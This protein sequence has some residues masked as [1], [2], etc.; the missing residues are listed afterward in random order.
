M[1]CK[2]DK[3]QLTSRTERIGLKHLKQLY[4]KLIGDDYQRFCQIRIHDLSP[5]HSL[6]AHVLSL[7]VEGS[8]KWTLFVLVACY[9]LFLSIELELVLFSLSLL[10]VTNFPAVKYLG[11][12]MYCIY[13]I[14]LRSNSRLYLTYFT[15]IYVLRVQRLT[16]CLSLSNS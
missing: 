9:S 5:P 14:S 3:K 7:T 1:D 16:A 11:L 4:Q 15:H 13:K 2:N 10:N 6:F 12:Y 8:L